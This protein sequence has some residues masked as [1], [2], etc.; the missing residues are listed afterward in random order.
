VTDNRSGLI[1]LKKAN[2]F[3]E[4]N[5]KTAMQSAANLA[6]GQCGLRDGSR[7]GMWRLPTKDE[8]KAMID[9]KYGSWDKHGLAISNAAGTGPWK[10]G[11]AFSGVQSNCYWSSAPFAPG[12]SLAWGMSFGC[13]DVY[14]DDKTLTNYVWPLRGGE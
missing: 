14:Y 12:T 5:W 4:Q 9:K 3:G 2:C 6:H 8:L 13:G 10:E 7:A 11:D 1:W